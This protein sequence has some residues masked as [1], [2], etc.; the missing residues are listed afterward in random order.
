VLLRV[1]DEARETRARLDDMES[2]LRRRFQQL[3]PQFAELHIRHFGLFKVRRPP[4]KAGEGTDW[5]WAVGEIE[6]EPP[7]GEVARSVKSWNQMIQVEIT[8]EAAS[9]S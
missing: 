9:A 2:L 7:Q 4:Q 8:F 1:R 6:E 3:E 5:H